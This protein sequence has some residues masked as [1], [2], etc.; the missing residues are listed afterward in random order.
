MKGNRPDFAQR[1][2][3]FSVTPNRT[4]A[5]CGI[6]ISFGSVAMRLILRWREKVGRATRPKDGSRCRKKTILVR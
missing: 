3:V 4:A 6:S 2:N 5:W 1:A